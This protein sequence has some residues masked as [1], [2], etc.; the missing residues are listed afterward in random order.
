MLIEG[1][2]SEEKSVKIGEV[3]SG[4]KSQDKNG[5]KSGS[6]HP[7]FSNVPQ[8]LEV[9]GL[10]FCSLELTQTPSFQELQ[11]KELLEA[12]GNL[13]GKGKGMDTLS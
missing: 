11:Y 13:G 1:T 6:S 8:R 10:G 9:S 3:G 7:L 2:F 12:P 5:L 4:R